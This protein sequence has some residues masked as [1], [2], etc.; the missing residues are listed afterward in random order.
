[1][2]RI[3]NPF[4]KT[5][6]NQCFGCSVHNSIGLKMS[7]FEEGEEVC[8]QWTPRHDLQGYVNVLHGGIQATLLDE[9]A[10]WTIYVK[11]G[12]GGVTSSMKVNYLKPVY[13]NRGDVLVKARITARDHK[14]ISVH[15]AIYN[16]DSELCT[17]AEVIYF[18]LPEK[19]ARERY[20]YPGREAFFEDSKE[21][22]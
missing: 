12:T 14:T 4:N 20:L 2:R 22:N 3:V 9:L 19:I 10:S 5:D 13:V 17:E 18:V 16:A 8:S 15:T 7:F 1:M 11:A 6:L 21:N